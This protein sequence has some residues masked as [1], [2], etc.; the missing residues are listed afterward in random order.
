M[1]VWFTNENDFLKFSEKIEEARK[2]NDS[3]EFFKIL[4]KPIEKA[5]EE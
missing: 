2:M 1:G 5:K 4:N 3:L